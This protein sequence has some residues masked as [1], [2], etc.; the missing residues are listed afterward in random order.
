M[1]SYKGD[2]TTLNALRFTDSFLKLQIVYT[3]KV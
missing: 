3:V 2:A 1:Y